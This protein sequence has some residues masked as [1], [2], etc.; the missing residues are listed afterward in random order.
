[1]LWNKY[2]GMRV[3]VETLAQ[4]LLGLRRRSCDH[5]T[6]IQSVVALIFMLLGRDRSLWSRFAEVDAADVDELQAA[7]EREYR[8]PFMGV[9]ILQIRRR[10]AGWVIANR[11]GLVIELRAAERLT[12]EFCGETVIEADWFDGAIKKLMDESNGRVIENTD[13]SFVVRDVTGRE[14]RYEASEGNF[15]KL[16]FARLQFNG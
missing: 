16:W 12:I 7:I 9:E 8:P 1:M 3:Q 4:A 5:V 13:T 6:G 14:H 11:N 2:A 10:N 15:A